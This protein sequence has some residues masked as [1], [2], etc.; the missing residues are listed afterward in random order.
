MP[1]GIFDLLVAFCG[2]ISSLR[3]V[4]VPGGACLR[5]SGSSRI[6][7]GGRPGRG[8][9]VFRKGVCS[10]LGRFATTRSVHKQVADVLASP[11]SHDI[12]DALSDGTERQGGQTCM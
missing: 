5:R 7:K 2:T 8:S 10:S 11:L 9:A 1:V 3:F 4:T 6:P 12:G